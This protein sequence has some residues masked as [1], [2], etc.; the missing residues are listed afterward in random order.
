[1]SKKRIP[2][3]GDVCLVRMMVRRVGETIVEVIPED[4][5]AIQAITVLHTDIEDSWKPRKV[6]DVCW[7]SLYRCTILAVDGDSCFVREEYRGKDGTFAPPGNEV[8]KLRQ[9]KDEP[10]AWDD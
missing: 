6:G 2:E 5:P 7:H 9:L 10:E 8:Y 1:M 4:A 3:E